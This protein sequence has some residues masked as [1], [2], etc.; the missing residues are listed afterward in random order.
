MKTAVTVRQVTSNAAALRRA[1]A[2]LTEQD[3]Y[4]GVPADDS[5]RGDLKRKNHGS[6]GREN[7]GPTNAEIAYWQETGIPSRNVPARPAL[8]PAIKD[9]QGEVVELLKDAAKK[10]LEGNE[11]AVNTALN[12]IG[13][14]GEKAVR[15]RFVNND[16]PPLADSTLD[17]HP[18][19]K[20]ESG[21]AVRDKK[22]NPLRQKSRREKGR[23]NP[24]I[25]TGQNRKA[26]TYVMR[27]RGAAMIT[28][29]KA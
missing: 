5:E 10:A 16:W 21:E 20:S 4:I 3:V 19:V 6:N 22:G 18:I 2:A 12:K 8:L 26:Y 9:I 15:A 28:P 11:G 29:E 13:L 17:Y 27:K 1:V 14:L 7:G 24:R 25:D 23:V